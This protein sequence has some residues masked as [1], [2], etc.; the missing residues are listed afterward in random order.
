M[1]LKHNGMDHIKRAESLNIIQLQYSPDSLARWALLASKNNQGPHILAQ[2]NIGCPDNTHPKLKIYISELIVDRYEYIFSMRPASWSSGQ[3][4]WLLIMRSR[5]RFAVLPWGFFL[6][7]EDP[8][9]DHGLGS[10]VEFRFKTPPGTS[11]SYI[12]FHLIGT[13]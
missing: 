12:T 5:V 6:E 7:G 4:F 1:F 9:G 2:V 13:T 11:Y 8:L 10:L 3:S